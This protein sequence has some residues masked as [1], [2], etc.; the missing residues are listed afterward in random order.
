MASSTEENAAGGILT[1]DPLTNVDRFY[2]PDGWY[3]IEDW[4][5]DAAQPNEFL[6]GCS[7]VTIKAAEIPHD[8]G[9][10]T[11]W[12]R[13]YWVPIYENGFGIGEHLWVTIGDTV[14][15]RGLGHGFK[16]FSVVGQ[17]GDTLRLEGLKATDLAFQGT[18]VWRREPMESDY[19]FDW[20]HWRE[21]R[22]EC[23]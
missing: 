9:G 10:N 21:L 1:S 18:L 5:W 19:D 4:Y 13:W 20:D 22:Q 17:K 14:F 16:G 7:S 12:G 6:L 15:A 8:T 3:S 2:L 23:R 11:R